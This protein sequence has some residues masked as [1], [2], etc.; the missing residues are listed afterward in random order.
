[1]QPAT[2]AYDVVVVAVAHRQFKELGEAGI[3][4]FG[5]ARSIIYDI[6]YLLPAEAVDERL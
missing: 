5:K 4:A 3:R 2:E 1:M 6:K